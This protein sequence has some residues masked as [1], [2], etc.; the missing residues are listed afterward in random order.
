MNTSFHIVKYVESLTTGKGRNVAI[1]AFDGRR[2]RYRT[3]GVEGD[4]IEPAYFQSMAM[5]TPESEWVFREW[6]N[7]LQ[8]LAKIRNADQFDEV[9]ARL[10]SSKSGFVVSSSGSTDI[11]GENGQFE[12]TMD[13]LFGQYVIVPKVS[14]VV[15]F[16]NRLA[17]IFVPAESAREQG[18]IFF[19][20]PAVV[21]VESEESN[22]VVTLEFSHLYSG[23]N[24]IGFDT[25]ILQ[26]AKQ[27]LLS[28]KADR[29]VENFTNSVRTGYLQPDRCVL[30]Y[31]HAKEKHRELLDRF[32]GVAQMMDVFDE[33]TPM[34]ISEMILQR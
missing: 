25:L 16:E 21:E 8:S 13:R 24:P 2:G 12:I 7:W 17:S 26:G 9:I 33:T 3:I 19:N 20:E 22:D 23:D 30:L 10:K 11:S 5:K 31:G 29:I 15:V 18:Y 32:S 6:A 34:K 28:L 1:L 27:D 4:E 14:P